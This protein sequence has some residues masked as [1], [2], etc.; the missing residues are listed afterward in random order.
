MK[1]IFCE[2]CDGTEFKKENGMFVCQGC[3]TSYSVE[4]ARGMMREV[5]GDAPAS[6]GA[7][8]VSVPIG[9]PNQAQIDNILVLASTAYEAQNYKETE[10]YCNRAI[11]LD[12][13][14]Y[15]A[16]NLKGKA[17]GWQST[18]GNLRIEEAAH[19]FCKAID[20]APEDERDSVKDEAVEEIQRLG[21]A[22]VALRKKRFIEKPQGELT[23]FSADVETIYNAL[24][25]LLQHGNAV[26]M[27]QEY[28]H[29]I[30]TIM[31]EAGVEAAEKSDAEYV[32]KTYPETDDFSEYG[33][34][35]IN[36]VSLIKG[37]L[38]LNDNEDDEVKLER[39]KKITDIVGMPVSTEPKGR[40]VYKK[41]WSSYLSKYVYNVDKLLS[42]RG[43]GLL[44]SSISDQFGNPTLAQI[45]ESLEKKIEAKKEEERKKAEAEKQARIEAYWAEHAEEKKALVDERERLGSE[46][47]EIEAKISK[48]D[49]QINAI[50]SERDKK[51]APS[52]AEIDKLR[53]Q[54]KDLENKRAGL[55]MFAGKEKKKIG[56]ETA[57][58]KGRIDSLSE[59]VNEEKRAI[60]KD[61]Q[62]RIDP[63][64][65]EKDK[66]TSDRD[67]KLK[68]INAI[69]SELTKDPEE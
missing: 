58:L 37:S 20:F 64:Q 10:N 52:E 53:D 30:C 49:F 63:L 54:I 18:I 69:Y 26:E 61:Y 68:R 31:Y 8:A 41:E 21:L 28:L 12:V 42:L 17:V 32:A 51:K 13:S 27:S 35:L 19:S 23:G 46:V 14:C 33:A 48:C 36:C 45:Q 11:E 39:Y 62:T 50:R 56:E 15:K 67:T 60:G 40:F 1:K 66:L 55:G 2:L 47:K 59:K 22:L 44:V 34:N 6:A 9:N 38:D 24:L 29:Q 57:A 16:W 7:P 43:I 25:V 3:G 5:E 4:E 65:K